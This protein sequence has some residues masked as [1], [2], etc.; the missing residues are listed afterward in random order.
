MRKKDRGRVLQCA[1]RLVEFLD[2]KLVRAVGV[3]AGNRD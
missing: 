1:Q 2:A 3:D